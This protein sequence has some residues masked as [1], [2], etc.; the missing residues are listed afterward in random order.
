M[1]RTLLRHANAHTGFVVELRT[2]TMPA[3]AF[4]FFRTLDAARA[5]RD[6]LIAGRAWRPAYGW[7]ESRERAPEKGWSQG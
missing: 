6:A 5:Y 3:T 1:R 2:S 4:F 7:C